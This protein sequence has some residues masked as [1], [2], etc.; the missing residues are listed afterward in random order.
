MKIAVISPSTESLEIIR[1]HLKD[2]PDAP[3]ITLTEGGMN[4]LTTV[5]DQQRPDLVIITGTSAELNQLVPL[6]CLSVQ[7][8]HTMII[9]LCSDQ[10]P[11]FLVNAMRAGVREV[12]PHPVGGMEL[13][14]AVAR[15]EQ[16]LGITTR[17]RREG[18]ILAFMPCKGGSGAT[19]LVTNLA[20]QL[21]STS[22]KVLLIDCNLQFGDA[23]LF[24]HDGKPASSLADLARE[25]HRLDASFLAS[26]VVQITPSFSILAAPDD[27]GQSM[28]VK[29]EHIERLL[30]L[31]ASIYD[32]ILVDLGRVLDPVTIKVLDRAESIYP[33]L[34]MTLPFIRDASRLLAVFRSLGYP[35]EKI[36]LLV[37]RYE[38]GGDVSLADL[39]QTLGVSNV[40][41][42]P[43]SYAAVARS[44]NQGVPLARIAKGNPVTRSLGELVQSL[45]PQTE[46]AGNWFGRILKLA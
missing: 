18:T 35:P 5:A 37:N 25:I 24:A 40:R 21:A 6:E 30:N 7:H 12:L 34:Q 14:A 28:E 32:Y 11:E 8:P 45:I 44:V 41:T 39:E 42:I 31:A 26:S 22:S 29:P 3:L 2:E 46:T 17:P 43:N 27:P 9:M 16:K 19:F 15:A 23:V 10:T 20:F 13:R 36:R 38:K 33:V 4:K 1:R